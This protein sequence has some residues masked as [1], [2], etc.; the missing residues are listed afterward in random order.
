MSIYDN[1]ID[2]GIPEPPRNSWR[3]W[4]PLTDY[5]VF[6]GGDIYIRKEDI[7]SICNKKNNLDCPCLKTRR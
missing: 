7:C 3:R 2:K 4:L 5:T 6:I 1:K